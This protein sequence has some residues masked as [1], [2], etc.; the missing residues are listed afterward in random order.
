MFL[1]EKTAEARRRGSSGKLPGLD[2]TYKRRFRFRRTKEQINAMI[3]RMFEAGVN[4]LATRLAWAM[5]EIDDAALIK[6]IEE[7]NQKGSFCN[8]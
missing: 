5:A 7:E 1:A 3:L 4:G 6:D 2:E 8:S